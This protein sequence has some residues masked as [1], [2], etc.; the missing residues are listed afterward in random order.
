MDNPDAIIVEDAHPAIV[1]REVWDAVHGRPR[2]PRTARPRLLSGLLW[3]DGHAY[4]GDSSRGQSFYRGPR[5]ARGC[6]WLDDQITDDTVWDAFV[7]LATAPAFV[8]RLMREALDEREQEVVAAEIEYLEGQVAKLQRRLDTLVNMRADG[9]IDKATYLAKA[10]EA[11]D[12]LDRLRRELAE[13][14]SKAVV[15][16]GTEAARV[17]KAVQTLIAGRTRL[18]VAQ[19]RRILR[20]IVRRVDVEVESQSLDLPRDANGRIAGRGRPRWRITNV[21][22]RLA[23]PPTNATRGHEGDDV[24]NHALSGNGAA[25]N[26]HV[27]QKVTTY[28]DCDQAP[29]WGGDHQAG[30]KVTTSSCS[31]R[32]AA[33]RR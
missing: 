7:S 3:I 27:G 17:V 28:S 23:L 32:P 8:E 2:T 6:P 22:F 5:G 9:E 15:H 14:R 18:T 13:Q 29:E 25:S 33:A 24:A 10:G 19:K 21:G 20:S 30:Q 26:G 1:S 31:A 11:E 4:G 12:S 16:D